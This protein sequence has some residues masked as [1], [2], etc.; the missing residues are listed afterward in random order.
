LL[1]QVLLEFAHTLG[2]E[3]S[4]QRIL[5]RLL[6]SIIDILPVTGAGVMLMGDRRQLHFAAASDDRIMAIER[7]QNELG[8]GPCLEAY[9][10]GLPV[11]VSDLSAD[12]RFPRF[13]PR[14]LQDGLAAVFTFPLSLDETRLGALDLYRDTTGPLSD[15]DLKAAQILTDVAA[16]YL[17]NAQARID[18]SQAVA[19][20]HHRSLHDPLTG[21][22]NRILFTEVLERAVA[23]A[24]RSHHVAAVLFIDLDGFKS[25]NDNHGHQV[26][27]L[28]LAAAAQRLTSAVRPGDTLARI[29]GDEFVIL[30]E[31]LAS[32]EDAETVAQRV[33]DSMSAPFHLS[34]QR[35]SL[36]ASVG[37]AFSGSGEDLPET[38]L[39]DADLAMYHAKARGGGQLHVIDPAARLVVQS[40]RAFETELR[41]AAPRDELRLLYQPIVA[42][43]SGELVAAEALLRWDNPDRGRVMPDAIIPSAERTGFIVELGEWVLTKAC[44]D[45]LSWQKGAVPVPGIAVNVSASQLMGPAFT[46]TV[47]SVL[48]ATGTDPSALCLEVTESVFLADESRAG[49][50]LEELKELGV[51]LSLDD[52]GTGYS[53]PNYLWRFSFDNLKIDRSFTSAL[54]TDQTARYIVRSMVGLSH[55]MHLNVIAEGVETAD[56]LSHL[57]ELGADQAQG[58]HFSR[59]LTPAQL[60]DYIRAA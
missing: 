14:A 12:T 16:A 60:S 9:M 49:K 11:S 19:R 20:L 39:R 26:G 25:I 13:S 51:R 47:Q 53:S 54:T 44:Q 38:L 1:A 28:L 55:D 31:D 57:S 15:D 24:R 8:E 30:C 40:R 35:L 41:Q 58:F 37:I 4:I 18:A 59:P 46:A 5:D 10:Y 56:E 32:S 34:D 33:T 3:F 48:D 36:S 52:F 42:V 43:G 7:L 23:R 29:G 27:D 17:F 45:W 21:L 22:A 50:V 6:D 2:S